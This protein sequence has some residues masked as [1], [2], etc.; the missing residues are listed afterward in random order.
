MSWAVIYN[1]HCKPLLTSFINEWFIT[2]N[3]ENMIYI[4]AYVSFADILLI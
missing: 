2:V 3:T 4:K 1:S